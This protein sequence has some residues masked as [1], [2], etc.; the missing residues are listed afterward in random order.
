MNSAGS[1][2]TTASLN[3][4]YKSIDMPSQIV[5][6]AKMILSK[7]KNVLIFCA[8]IEEA[9]IVIKKIPGS[10][11]LTGE[12]KTTERERILARFK[13]GEIK[14][15][16]NVGVLTTGFDMPSL[17]AVLIARSTM[18]LALYYQIVG[19]VMRIFTYPDGTKKEGWVVDLGGNINF[20]GKIETM[21]IKEVKKGLFSI[22]NNG[23][24]LTNTPFVK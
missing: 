9:K 3:R 6:Y 1:D 21:I 16:T 12:T 13:K 5:K 20:F 19:R 18:S 4:L 11:I 24:Q 22:W 15:L 10:A 7:R 2:F 23:R 17:E 14:C 8:T